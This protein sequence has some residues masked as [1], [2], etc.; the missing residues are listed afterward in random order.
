MSFFSGVFKSEQLGSNA[1]FYITLPD[2]I[3][4]CKVLY[5]LHGLS[6]N[7]TDWMRKTSIERYAN[8]R[9]TAVIMPDGARSFYTDMAFGRNYYS[10]ISHELPNYINSVFNLNQ[11]RENTFIAGLSM[12]GYGAVKIALSNPEKYAG[13]ASL[14]GA[15]DFASLLKSGDDEYKRLILLIL[16]ENP[17]VETNRNNLFYLIDELSKTDAPKPAIYQACGTEDFLY[18][19]NQN[20]KAKISEFDFNYK[21]EEGPGAHTWDFWDE[22]IQKAMDF[23]ILQ[24]K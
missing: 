6:D 2:N 11:S 24:S 3:K 22:Y 20:F 15:L 8:Q 19:A 21:Y 9:N 16:G 14:S 7:H 10:Y 23:L 13:A 12:G 1:N 5:L 4:N 17:E 18:E